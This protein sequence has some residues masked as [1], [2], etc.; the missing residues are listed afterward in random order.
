VIC[1]KIDAKAEE[2][3]ALGPTFRSSSKKVLK[4]A[5]NK[6]KVICI[7]KDAKVDFKE[8]ENIGMFFLK[9]GFFM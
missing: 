3:L 5:F 9:F 1:V 2:N 4:K 7:K 8:K 6:L